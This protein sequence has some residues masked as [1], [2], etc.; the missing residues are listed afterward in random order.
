MNDSTK[1][2]SDPQSSQKPDP[3]AV[4]PSQEQE[5]WSLQAERVLVH[6]PLVSC[7]RIIAGH[8]GRRT[9]ET[10]LTSGLPVP[11]KGITPQ[12]FVRAAQRADMQA[13]LVEKNLDGIL[14]DKN[15]PC[16]LKLEGGQ[17]CIIW[18]V[19][20]SGHKTWLVVEY[21]ETAGER[22]QIAQD[23]LTQSYSG[24]AFF[25]RPVSRLDDRV[26]PAKID[27][28]SDWF[29]GTLKE[30]MK[31][32]RD[33]I[34]AAVMINT[35]ALGSSLFIMIV[36]DRVVPNAA[37]ETLWVLAIGV[38][39]VFVFD[40]ILKN[41]RAYFLD[42]SGRHADV[43]ISSRLF[44]QIM[45]IKMAERPSSAGVLANHMREFEGI[46]DFFTSATMVAL[47]DLPFIFMFIGLIFIIGGPIAIV[48][49]AA[50]PILAIA[51]YFGQR[52]MEDVICQSMNENAQKNALLFETVSG[53]ET[54]K[55]QS[56]EGHAQRKW[57]ELTD[58]A[59]R[60]A[61]QS[62]RLSAVV[63]HF[64]VFVQQ[65]TNI[66]LVIVGVYLIAGGNLS[67]GGLIAAVILSGRAMAPLSQVTGLLT[68]FKQSQEALLQLDALMK[69]EVERP[70]GK[71]FISKPD[72]RGDI[73]FKNVT[74]HYPGQN[75]PA[76]RDIS[77]DM[78]AGEK[79]AVIGAVG[80]GK[81]TLERLL[82]NLYQPESGS[83]QVDGTDVRQIDPG[84]LR[85]AVGVVQQ[86]PHLFYGSIRE[87]ITMGYENAPESAV[88]QA[89]QQSGVIEFLGD[90]EHGLDT[91]IGERG[92]ALSGGQQQAVAVARAL[93]YDPP[94][95]ILDEP[96]ASMDP[97][98]EKRLLKRLQTLCAEK[99][100][101][102]I[103]HKA[104]L[105]GMV[106]KIILMDRGQ[107]AAFGPRDEIIEG[108]Q[109]RKYGTQAENTDV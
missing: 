34:L 37:F 53:L 93:L 35:F 43:K 86:V 21:P 27:Q 22:K 74:F 89:A 104:T 13:S 44:E 4:H 79:I 46:R 95:M 65:I 77:F 70:A 102:L 62:R 96:T 24:Y 92:E 15:F 5:S 76:L 84:D 40:L 88:L 85:R 60:T 25:V 103:T 38:F 108:L 26:G 45:A 32:Y 51:G 54:I 8:F 39:I 105:L 87:N 73:S 10:A 69:K 2:E 59:S 75:L 68:R 33:V 81:T 42:V 101:F 14:Q 7:L 91:Q 90:T 48:P 78:K 55:T 29:W 100:T 23:D 16:L 36:Y 41:L 72:I 3:K 11:K 83:V 47:I 63:M 97:A 52:A 66:I 98:S 28:A 67:M 50:I 99:T 56:A 19:K 12:L 106:D 94:I 49:L 17:G 61:V 107:V 20:Q 31:I 58:R 64:S 82:M 71:T 1:P 30:N 9:S 109:S 6:D 57:E 18:D 80:S